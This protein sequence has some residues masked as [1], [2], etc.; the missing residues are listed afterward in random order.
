MIV[1]LVILCAVLL[2]SSGAYAKSTYSE[3]DFLKFVKSPMVIKAM[4][5]L[6]S[7]FP[8]FQSD[9][10]FK[11]IESLRKSVLNY[12]TGDFVKEYKKV[13]GKK[14]NG[15]SKMLDKLDPNAIAFQHHYISGNKSPLGKKDALLRA[16]DK[17][18]WSALHARYH[19]DF[20]EH[21]QSNKLYDIFLVDYQ[22]G[23][24]VYS[25]FKELDFA[26]NLQTGPYAKSPIG[27]L[28]PNVASMTE[29]EEFDL[30][31]EVAYFPSYDRKAVFIGAP[32]FDK[33]TKVGVLIIQ[34]PPPE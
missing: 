20:R 18:K 11:D 5:S 30:S 26:T 33:G 29:E 13:T 9:N 32:I 28:F 10:G 22:S 17:S 21:L 31:T 16:E 25:V 3:G 6:G 34:L 7:T 14:P 2:S 27:Q 8:K 19:P 4:K 15:L 1:R 24:I 23:D 12:Y